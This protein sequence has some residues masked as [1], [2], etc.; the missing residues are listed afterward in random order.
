MIRVAAL[1]SGIN[2][3]SAR[4]RVRQ[5]IVPLRSLGV[6]VI[7]YC[8]SVSQLARLPGKLGRIR[9]RYMPPVM[10]GQAL[11]NAILRLPGVVG[12]YRA[13]VAWIER[14]FVPGLDG[15]I[16]CTKSPRVLDV[17]DAVWL[18]TLFGKAATQR[19]ARRV[20]AIIAGNAYLADWYGNF[21]RNI[22]V[23]PTAIDCD[24]FAPPALSEDAVEAE[25]FIIG[26]TGTAGNFRYLQTLERPL[27]HFLRSHPAA[28]LKI[29]ADKR[30]DLP[31]I[32]D[33]QLEFVRWTPGNEAVS[34]RNMDVGLMPLV[35]DEWTRGKC[36]FKMLQYMATGLPVIVSPVGMNAEVLKMGE[37]GARASN[38]EDWLG[39]LELLHDNS[40]LRGAMGASGR[41]IVLTTFSVPTVASQLANAFSTLLV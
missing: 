17:D 21:C 19:L 3:P 6:E 18:S 35:D 29:V 32:P 11:L 14:N 28:R 27:S 33:S 40:P 9:Q 15:A 2:V 22:F 25:Q 39:A 16:L 7:D 10:A 24:R 36:S 31:L 4:F 30:P 26:W 12:T 41:E 1:T 37:C 5:H 13:D 34:L 38:E 20:D 23:I 8:P